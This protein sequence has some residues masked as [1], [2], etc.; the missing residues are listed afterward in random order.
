MDLMN[1]ESCGA[2]GSLFAIPGMT[3]HAHCAQCGLRTP[4]G[5]SEVRKRKT[6]EPT[7]I[8]SIEHWN[9]LQSKLARLNYLE[10]M[11]AGHDA[12]AG[13]AVTGRL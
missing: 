3:P 1:C 12:T 10:A 4:P 8:E 2:S 9:A 5:S 6:L 7:V 11:L 13:K